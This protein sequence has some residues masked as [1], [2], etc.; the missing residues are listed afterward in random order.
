MTIALAVAGASGR[1]GR[2]VLGQAAADDGFRLV[3]A[4]TGES[5][6]AIELAAGTSIAP[7]RIG[8]CASRP[9]VVIDFSR[10]EAF[11]DLLAW[12]RRERVALVS[13]T[14]G[15]DAG[16]QRTLDAAAAD[17]PV[18]WSANFSLGV[19]VLR[20]LVA[21]AAQALPDWDAEIVEA[22]HAGKR[23]APSGTALAL[24]RELAQARGQAFDALAAYD[25]H[26]RDEARR[27]GEIG[28]AVVRAG[29][30]VGEHMVMLAGAGERLELAHRATDRAVFA[31]GALHAARWLA[32]RGPGRYGL[33]DCISE[34]S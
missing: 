18:L 24:G 15:L 23:D 12:C 33:D 5:A 14:T 2:L 7:G 21:A 19:A 16:Q 3:G 22:H 4:W 6:T 17:I 32:G 25:R 13:G 26:G 11:D 30:I 34:P 20:R 29:D 9:D 28:F 27:A 31:R 10:A 1:M 8:D